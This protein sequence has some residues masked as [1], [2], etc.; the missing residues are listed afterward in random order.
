MNPKTDMAKQLY[1]ARK[2]KTQEEVRKF[3]EARISLVSTK[4]ADVIRDILRTFDD[5]TEQLDVMW[6]LVHD[7]ESLDPESYVRELSLEIPNMMSTARDWTI[8][9][10]QRIINTKDYLALYKKVLKT[11]PKNT[12]DAHRDVLRQIAN[13]NPKSKKLINTLLKTI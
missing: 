3:E 12:V 4:R 2:M 10:L 5:S 9:L 8:I 6:G 7:V 13:S 1:Q 11:L